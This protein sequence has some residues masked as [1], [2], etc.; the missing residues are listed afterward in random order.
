M[1]LLNTFFKI[2]GHLI[3]IAIG[4]NFLYSISADFNYSKIY[5]NETRF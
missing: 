3:I 1:V 2:Y 5:N 4:L